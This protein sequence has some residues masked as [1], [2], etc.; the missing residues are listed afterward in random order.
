MTLGLGREGGYIISHL[1]KVKHLRWEGK[2]S[3]RKGL[4][5]MACLATFLYFWYY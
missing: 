5:E 1:G 3:Q 2:C 4:M